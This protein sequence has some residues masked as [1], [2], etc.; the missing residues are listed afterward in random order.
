MVDTSAVG[1]LLQRNL[2]RP[3]SYFS[4]AVVRDRPRIAELELQALEMPC[5]KGGGDAVSV[6]SVFHG[7]IMR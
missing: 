6:Y 3:N 7:T 2:C 4:R 5:A 1:V